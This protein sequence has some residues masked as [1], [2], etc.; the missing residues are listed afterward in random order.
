MVKRKTQLTLDSGLPKRE[1]GI[2]R[3][4]LGNA[5]VHPQR[6]DTKP[7]QLYGEC[8]KE[9]DEPYFMAKY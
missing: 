3:D 4:H 8:R 1:I 6:G 9:A 2:A 5:V 7:Y